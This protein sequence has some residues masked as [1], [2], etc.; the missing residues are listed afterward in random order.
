MRGNALDEASLMGMAFVPHFISFWAK[1]EE[2]NH[3][4]RWEKRGDQI[5]SSYSSFTRNTLHTSPNDSFFLSFDN[6][7]EDD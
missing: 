6:E 7:D 5:A 4:K 2:A 1:W 3:N